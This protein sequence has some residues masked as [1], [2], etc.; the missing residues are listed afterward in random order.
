MADA[1]RLAQLRLWLASGLDADDRVFL[2]RLLDQD[3]L[4]IAVWLTQA[5]ARGRLPQAMKSLQEGRWF[6]DE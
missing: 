4:R 6:T 1:E 5:E 2:L 3:R